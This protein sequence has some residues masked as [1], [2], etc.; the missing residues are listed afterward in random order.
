MAFFRRFSEAI[1]PLLIF[2]LSFT[3]GNKHGFSTGQDIESYG[4]LRDSGLVAAVASVDEDG[5]SQPKA[6]ATSQS[7]AKLKILPP[8]FEE[9]I[10]LSHLLSGKIQRLLN[11]DLRSKRL[12]KK[13]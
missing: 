8:I 5:D 12:T 1:S 11:L 2:F 7:S 6:I 9:T 13:S 3:L 10:G 4:K